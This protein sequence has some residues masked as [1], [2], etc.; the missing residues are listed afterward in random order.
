[1]TCSRRAAYTLTFD[2]T[3]RMAALGPLAYRAEPHS[4]D[5]CELHAAKT[6]VPA[7]WTLIKP[8]PIGAPRD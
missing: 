2:Y 3:D 7:G 4:Y 6:S 1:M 5:L 8:V